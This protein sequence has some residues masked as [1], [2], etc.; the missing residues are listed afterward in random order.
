MNLKV[1]SLLSN[2]LFSDILRKP[3]EEVSKYKTQT[4]NCNA[5]LTNF[6]FI[7]EGS[8]GDEIG[9]LLVS[10]AQCEETFESTN[11]IDSVH[12]EPLN[13]EMFESGQ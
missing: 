11:C 8:F 6:P 4:K 2:E 12:M 5:F 1:L 3:E 7:L 13:S 10:Q 9:G